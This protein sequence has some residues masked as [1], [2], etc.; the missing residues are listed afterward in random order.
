MFVAAALED[1][2]L[3]NR[4]HDVK[5]RAYFI[6]FGNYITSYNID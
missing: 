4:R 3:V 2:L 1:L 6:G 5:G